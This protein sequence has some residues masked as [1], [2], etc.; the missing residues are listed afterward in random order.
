MQLAEKFVRRCKHVRNR[1]P[2]RLPRDYIRSPS[3]WHNLLRLTWI[4]L[5][6]LGLL[7]SGELFNEDR[8]AFAADLEI[9]STGNRYGIDF[10]SSVANVNLGTFDGSG[11]DVA[12]SPGQLDA[13]SWSIAGFSSGEDLSR[14]ISTGGV[15]S[16]GLYAFDRSGGASTPN[17]L[18]GVQPTGSDFTPGNITLSVLNNTGQSVSKWHID[19]DIFTFNNGDRSSFL[20]FSYAIGAGAF[21]EMSEMNYATPT[22][23]DSESAWIQ[24]ERAATVLAEVEQGE[25]LFLRWTSDDVDGSGSRDEFGLDNI[26][27]TAVPE[28]SQV[29]GLAII[30]VCGVVWRL[31]RRHSR[32]TP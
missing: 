21:Q 12:P 26:G 13:D 15:S 11:I 30:S 3:R 6:S 22:S 2:Q 24:D 28:P 10:D 4:T 20:N 27:V 1:E 17:I 29:A 8:T 25:Q 5:L 9:L 14:G 16:G 7:T 31:R 19:Y 32:V 23:S 18:L